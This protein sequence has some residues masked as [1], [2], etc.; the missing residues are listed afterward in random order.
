MLFYTK[1]RLRKVLMVTTILLTLFINTLIPYYQTSLMFLDVGQGDA[2]YLE[3]KGCKMLIDSYEGSFEFLKN[4]GVYTLD[5]LFLTHP[6]TDHIK[7]A[8]EITEAI[9]VENIYL[10]PYG[11]YPKLNGKIHHAYPDEQIVCGLFHIEVL[12]PVRAYASDNDNSIVLRI[13]AHE[14]TFLFTGDIEAEAELDLIRRY[15]LKSDVLKVSHHGSNTSTSMQFIDA[16]RPQDAI[17]SVGR[18]NRYGFP[19]PIVMDRIQND[20]R[21]IYRTDSDHTIIYRFDIFVR[22]W[23]VHLPFKADF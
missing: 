15:E 17:L 7:E 10:S 19:S 4:R 18:S 21:K 20:D 12:G 16:V 5:Y 1:I 8:Y 23:F 11:T 9:D 13:T 2:I 3:S 22:K 6:D 14:K